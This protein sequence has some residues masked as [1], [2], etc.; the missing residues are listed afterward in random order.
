MRGC[1]SCGSFFF[2]LFFR[3][4][5]RQGRTRKRK[6][7]NS[8]LPSCCSHR[9]LFVFL[10]FWVDG[11]FGGFDCYRLFWRLHISRFFAAACLASFGEL[12]LAFLKVLRRANMSTML[13]RIGRHRQRYENNLRLVS[14]Y[15]NVSY[16][17]V[18]PLC[19]VDMNSLPDFLMYDRFRVALS[20]YC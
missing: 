10:L 2:F 11:F 3:I 1:G 14:G 6:A 13:A 12:T 19:S 4:G 17:L 7:R 20:E 5:L 16:L 9:L 15:A 18:Q 8:V